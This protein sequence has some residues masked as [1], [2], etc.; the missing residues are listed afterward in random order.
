ML[1]VLVV[2]AVL[3]TLA[4]VAVPRFTGAIARANTAKIQTDLQTLD[5]AVAMYMAEHGSQ[6]GAYSE[7]KPYVTDFDSLKPPTGDCIIEGQVIAVPASEYS[8]VAD[9][10]DSSMKRAA[11]GSYTVIKF[12][13]KTSGQ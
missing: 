2:V 13:G 8:L 5:T 3:G 10:E 7:L 11:C 1:E 12:G 4:S 6:P 9:A